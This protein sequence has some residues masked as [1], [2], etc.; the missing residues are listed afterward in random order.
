MS[1]WRQKQQTA[2]MIHDMSKAEHRS[3][4]TSEQHATLT[5]AERYFSE[6]MQDPGY[7]KAYTEARLEL[8]GQGD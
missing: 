6:R 7:R 1:G 8:L 2:C 3:V 5:R 4:P